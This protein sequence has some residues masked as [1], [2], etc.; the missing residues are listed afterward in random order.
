MKYTRPST[1]MNSNAQRVRR[2]VSDIVF[3][4]LVHFAEGIVVV[5]G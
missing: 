2:E 5:H 3:A 4:G 1:G